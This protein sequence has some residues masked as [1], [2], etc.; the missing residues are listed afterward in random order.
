MADPVSSPST[1]D[2]IKPFAAAALRHIL[3]VGAGIIVA[4]GY[5]NS[6]GAEQLVGAGMTI[7]GIA[8]SWYEKYGRAQLAQT[9]ADAQALLHAKAQQARDGSKPAAAAVVKALAWLIVPIALVLLLGGPAGAQTPRPRPTGD[10]VKD[11]K[12]LI[13]GQGQG[14]DDAATQGGGAVGGQASDKLATIL[15]KPF[16]DLSDF[17]NSD[18]AAAATLAVQIPELQDNIGKSCWTA[19]GQFSAVVKAHPLPLTLHA[20]TDLEAFRLAAMAANNICHNASCSQIFTD[21]ANSIQKAAPINFGIPIPSL[22]SL[23]ANVPQVTSTMEVAVPTVAPVAPVTP[24][25]P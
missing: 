3:T 9:L 23:C 2:F 7:G 21:L 22:A 11:I 25:Q 19:F 6:S 17:I 20:A 8:W 5:A 16:K 14:S 12:T 24:T 1:L 4:H 13:G 18:M 10:A 15:A